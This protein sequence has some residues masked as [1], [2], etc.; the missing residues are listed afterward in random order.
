MGTHFLMLTDYPVVITS[1]GRYQRQNDPSAE[2]VREQLIRDDIV[3]SNRIVDKNIEESL[4]ELVGLH[5][6]SLSLTHD[7]ITIGPDDTLHFIVVEPDVNSHP[8]IHCVQ[9][10]LS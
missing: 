10:S 4:F 3:I 1:E 7:R 6:E 2:Y 9:F 8:V 5:K